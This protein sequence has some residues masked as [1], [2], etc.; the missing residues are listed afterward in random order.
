MASGAQA[1]ARISG[2]RPE[3]RTRAPPVTPL[4]RTCTFK[5]DSREV[6]TSCGQL[7]LHAD[8]R[9]RVHDIVEAGRPYR[10][11][12]QDRH[13]V[14]CWTRSP[15]PPTTASGQQLDR[16]RSAPVVTSVVL[17]QRESDC[18]VHDRHGGRRPLDVDGAR[19]DS[20]GASSSQQPPRRGGWSRLPNRRELQRGS[21]AAD[22]RRFRRRYRSIESRASLS[23]SA[24]ML[25]CTD[26]SV[27]SR[28]TAGRGRLSATVLGEIAVLTSSL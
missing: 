19:A 15:G 28:R 10:M 12:T 5:T 27:R 3:A 6:P 21:L 8:L 13:I 23:A 18:G 2:Q 24:S 25:C 16:T 4:P 26:L 22:F 1:N 20:E 14:Q 9:G 11:A 17:C 7:K